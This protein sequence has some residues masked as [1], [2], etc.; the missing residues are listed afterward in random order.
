MGFLHKGHLSLIKRAKAENDIVVVSIFVNPIQFSVN[1]DLDS[2]PN[3]FEGDCEKCRS[4][5]VDYVFHPSPSEMYIDHKT[6][7]HVSKLTENLCGIT[8]P[9]HFDGVCTVV[10]KLFNIIKPTNV[11]FGEKDAQQLAVIKKMVE[12]LNF[13]LKI[14]PCPIV[15]EENGLAMSSRNKYLSPEE[16]TAATVLNRAL[17]KGREKIYNG[18]SSSELIKIITAEISSEPLAKI[19]YVSVVDGKNLSPVDEVE[20]GVLVAVAVY[21]GNARLIDNFTYCE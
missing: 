13:D 20:K 18:M 19:D 2:Y 9:T 14:V 3:D 10:A 5:G 16:R 8:R 7:I 1:E 21:F 17:K 4:L 6:T 12:D 15:R 11:Y